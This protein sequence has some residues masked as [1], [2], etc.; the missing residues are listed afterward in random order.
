MTVHCVRDCKFSKELRQEF[1]E[2]GRRETSSVMIDGICTKSQIQICATGC[3]SFEEREKSN[4]EKFMK[5]ADFYNYSDLRGNY[6]PEFV[7]NL[8]SRNSLC[9]WVN[10]AI[11]ALEADGKRVVIKVEDAKE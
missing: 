6:S 9:I 11:H 5:R 1:G 2:L 8:I 4:W 3:Q 10:E 7:L